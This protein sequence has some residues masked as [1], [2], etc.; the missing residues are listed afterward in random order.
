MDVEEL[1]ARTLKFSIRI[2]KLVD[3]LPTTQ[4]ARVVGGQ[5]LKSGTSIGSNYR[6]AQHAS[7]PRHFVTV[8]EIAQREASETSY[9]L[10]VVM[11]SGMLSKTQVQP[12]FEECREIYAILTGTIL[13]RKQALEKAS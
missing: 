10:E 6:E 3:A 8:L 5:V 12:L 13:T 11:E 7:S 9:W 4:A 2:I 1:K